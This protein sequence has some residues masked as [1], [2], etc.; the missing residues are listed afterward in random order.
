MNE[1]LFWSDPASGAH[2][3]YAE[4]AIDV[5]CVARVPGEFR[6]S[7]SYELF[8]MLLAAIKAETHVALATGEVGVAD[9]SELSEANRSIGT[10]KAADLDGGAPPVNFLSSG[11][12]DVLIDELSDEQCVRANKCRIGVFT[13]G[14][15]GRPKLIWH[16]LKSLT[17]AIQV[18]PKHA[19]DV[20]GL[21]YG[22]THFAG[23]QV[24]FQ[25]IANRNPIVG[26]FGLGPAAMHEAIDEESITHLSA[27]PTF[28]R[29]LCTGGNVHSSVKAITLGG[30]QM[31]ESLRTRIEVMFP[32]ARVR[33]IYA[34]TEAGTVLVADGES[35]V[36]PGKYRDLVRILES[37]LQL[38][39]SLLADSI[40]HDHAGEY[41]KTGDLVD[42]LSEEPLRFRFV[43]RRTD[44]INV[45]GYKVNPHQVES[46]IAEFEEVAEARVYG[47]KNSVVG[48][49]V[50]CDIQLCEGEQLHE[51]AIKQ[52]LAENLARHEV[53]QIINFVESI[54]LTATGKKQRSK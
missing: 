41:F 5:G 50:C 10:S 6:A 31:E 12:I 7:G 48:N 28:Y 34:S 3:S 22:P 47:R 49:I 2:L 30:E 15:S 23:L 19:D 26:L 33:N 39:R 1:N 27:T 36:V 37:E 17:R 46:R 45:G 32:N 21:A 35:F 43:S 8:V 44:W 18:S 16:S 24:F 13:S 53:P 42:V 25:A 51:S 9:A 20:W 54:S 29:L 40:K 14:T 11:S 4:L 52:R 38:H